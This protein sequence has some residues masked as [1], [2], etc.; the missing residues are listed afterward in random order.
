MFEYVLRLFSHGVMRFGHF[1]VILTC[2]LHTKYISKHMSLD[3]HV[4]FSRTTIF[5]IFDL[6]HLFQIT[7]Y[8]NSDGSVQTHCL[9]Y[10]ICGA[11]IS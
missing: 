11:L 4:R 5:V 10:R 6:M 7:V 1:L 8:A 2:F 9:K 3:Q